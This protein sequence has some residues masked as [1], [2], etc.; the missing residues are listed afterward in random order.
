M[1]R[2][3]KNINPLDLK[4]QVALG[5]S[6]PFNGPGVFNS[7]YT[8]KDQLKS[9]IINFFLT[10]SGERVFNPNFGGNL[11]KEIF[12]QITT[13]TLS[14]IK[15]NIKESIFRN[16][17]NLEIKEVIVLGTE[18]QNK[19]SISVKYSVPN[20]AISDEIQINFNQ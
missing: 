18:D 15:S 1:A 9:N 8:T 11:R 4:P 17:P 20:L 16:F 14:D 7:T 13:G 12:E 5:V 10:N 3:I 19:I 6:V 2:I